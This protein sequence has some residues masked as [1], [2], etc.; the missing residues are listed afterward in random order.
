MR[1]FLLF[2]LCLLLIV[3][4]ATRSSTSAFLLEQD[5]HAMSDQELVAHEQQLSDEI[6]RSG[7]RSNG[8]VSVGVGFGRWG[9]SG[10]VGV[11]INQWLGGGVSSADHELWQRREEVRNEI[12]KRG[13]SQ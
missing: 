11:G 2:L 5:F 9:S 6:L 4:C 8:D 10:G 7:N 3:G 12:R 13:L 1:I